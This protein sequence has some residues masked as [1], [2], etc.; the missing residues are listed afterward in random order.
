MNGSDLNKSLT[1]SVGAGLGG[2]NAQNPN[3]KKL[4]HKGVKKD[5]DDKYEYYTSEDEHGRRI[6]KMRKKKK[7]TT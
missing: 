5:N 1:D 3:S 4:K 6:Q 7:K 2:K